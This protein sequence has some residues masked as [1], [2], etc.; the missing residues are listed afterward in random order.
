MT[1]YELTLTYK[2]GLI[3]RWGYILLKGLAPKVGVGQI[4]KAV[5]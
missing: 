5:T 3:W 1:K 4:S 2:K